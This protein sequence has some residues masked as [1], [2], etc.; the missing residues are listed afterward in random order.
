VVMDNG[1]LRKEDEMLMV[2]EILPVQ[3][4]K[5]ANKD[6][7][8][9]AVVFR[10]QKLPE[11]A[12]GEGVEQEA[13][14]AQ[15]AAGECELKPQRWVLN[16][17]NH[18]LSPHHMPKYSLGWGMNPELE[19]VGLTVVKLYSPEEVRLVS[20]GRVA[21]DD[22]LG[23][24]TNASCGMDEVWMDLAFEDVL[25]DEGTVTAGYLIEKACEKIRDPYLCDCSDL[26][27]WRRFRRAGTNVTT[28]VVD[29]RKAFQ[30]G[31]EVDEV[32]EMYN[33]FE[34][35]CYYHGFQQ[36]CEDDC[37]NWGMGALAPSLGVAALAT[38]L[39]F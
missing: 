9:R 35:M 23:N 7:V 8:G 18:T 39:T 17:K 6:A 31:G 36:T 32:H 28:C 10:R 29:D 26:C 1:V 37:S 20:T 2:L 16:E 14:D 12:D 5:K 4:P 21:S 3:M 33:R 13:L 24:A 30:V 34:R 25:R 19:E 27:R 22:G 11:C 38:F 15:I